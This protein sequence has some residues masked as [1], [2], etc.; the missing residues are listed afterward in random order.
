MALSRRFF[1]HCATRNLSRL[2]RMT[3]ERYSLADQV[4]RFE[5]AKSQNN[6]R[7]L[8]MRSTYEAEDIKSKVKDKVVLVVGASRGLGLEISKRL[9]ID[10]ADVIATA[11][12]SSPALDEAKVQQTITGVEVTDSDSLSKMCGEI[13]K[14]L[15]Y[16]IFN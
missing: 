11:R 3:D 14:P 15:D 12:T 1:S 8:D 13:G 7:Y 10:G 6:K 9:V 2:A 16:V 4:A 5:R